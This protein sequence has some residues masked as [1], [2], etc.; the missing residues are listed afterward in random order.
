MVFLILSLLVNTSQASENWFCKEESSV[1]RDNSIEA[2]GTASSVDYDKAKALAFESAKNEFNRV[3]RASSDC[4]GHDISINP[5]RT[6]CDQKDGIFTCYRLLEFVIALDI[7]SEP[8]IIKPYDIQNALSFPKLIKGM[9]KSKVLNIF[10]EPT[11]V[12]VDDATTLLIYNNEDFCEGMLGCG[13]E[14][15]RDKV[16]AYFSIKYK[17]TND[18]K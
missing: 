14:L 9:S 18:L 17:Y 12:H 13:I 2:C 10:G 5:K 4:A 8:K 3:C 16:V 6:S 1:R 15:E 11:S 7:G